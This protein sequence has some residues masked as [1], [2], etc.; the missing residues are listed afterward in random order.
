MVSSEVK[1]AE[2][3]SIFFHPSEQEPTNSVIKIKVF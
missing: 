2:E 3:F 1:E